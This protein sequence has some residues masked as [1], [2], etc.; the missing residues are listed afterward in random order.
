MKNRHAVALGKLGGPKGGR[1][2]ARALSP[3]RRRAIAREAAAARWGLLPEL[4]R[5][6]FW[7]YT[8][9]ALRLP[10]D[11][12]L[13]ML[14]V[15]AYG[16]PEQ[17]AWLRGRFGDARIRAWITRKRGKG[18]TVAQMASWVPRATAKRWQASNP[19]ALIWENR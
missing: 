2:R 1:A 10:A 3:D 19:G 8:F 16:N 6:L 4:L 14:H 15:L 18:L 17:S 11:E 13:V 5:P 12:D 7:S 9:E